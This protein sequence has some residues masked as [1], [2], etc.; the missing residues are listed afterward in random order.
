MRSKLATVMLLAVGLMSAQAPEGWHAAGSQREAYK[1]GID[2]VRVHGGKQSGFI[3]SIAAVEDGKFG[4][5]MQNIKADQYRGKTVKLST[6]VKTSQA[7][8]GAWVWLRI[9]DAKSSLLDN[10][11]DRLVKGTTD[12]HRYELVLPVSITAVGIAFG[13]GLSGS[14]QAWIDDVTLE[15]VS[16]ETPR[17]GS[18]PERVPEPEELEMHKRM[19]ASHDSKPTAAVNLDFE[20]DA[21]QTQR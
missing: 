18:L 15:T 3:Q 13:V 12:W 14:G 4:T 5:L 7:E 2:I 6:F 19:L 8:R 11:Q 21:R 20:Q 16:T 1:I 10:M 17:T 9:D